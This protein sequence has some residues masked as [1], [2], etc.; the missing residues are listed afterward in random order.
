MPNPRIVFVSY[1]K[2]D[3]AWAEWIAWVLEEDGF[4]ARIQAWDFHGN[5]VLEMDRAAK[6]AE[7][8]IILLSQAY[9]DANFTHPEWAAAFAKDPTSKNNT[10]IPVC[11][12]A[13]ALNGLLA[14]INYVDFI[15]KDE[16]TAKKLLIAR[17]TGLRG[18]PPVKP[19]FPGKPTHQAKPAFPSPSYSRDGGVGLAGVA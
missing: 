14:Q 5:F 9:L 12:G 18:K 15:G 8:T 6:E 13:V 17:L 19:A 7:Q 16:D 1:N 3:R 11:V 2:A 4:E 10:L